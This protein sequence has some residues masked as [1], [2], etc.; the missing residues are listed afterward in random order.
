MGID[1]AFPLNAL[2]FKPVTLVFHYHPSQGR[3]QK[4]SGVLT[5]NIWG[6]TLNLVFFL[7]FVTVTHS[8]Q[9]GFELP[10]YGHTTS[11]YNL[12]SFELYF[13]EMHIVI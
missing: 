10:K 2:L 3:S 7:A 13:L 9:R 1:P 6:I 11:A 5:F 8:F 12:T 4:K